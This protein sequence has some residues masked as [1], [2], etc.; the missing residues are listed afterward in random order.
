MY[1]KP[2][3]PVVLDKATMQ[4]AADIPQL[5]RNHQSGG[6]IERDASS[7]MMSLNDVVDKVVAAHTMALRAAATHGDSFSATSPGTAAVQRC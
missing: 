7:G 2:L 5:V 1:E 3:L 4:R 6:I